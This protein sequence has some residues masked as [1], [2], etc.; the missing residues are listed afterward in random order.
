[1][2][3]KDKNPQEEDHAPGCA[4]GRLRSPVDRRGPM[5]LCPV[6]PRVPRGLYGSPAHG[7]H[8]QLPAPAAA[9]HPQQRQSRAGRPQSLSLRPPHGPAQRNPAHATSI[10][11]AAHAPSV[12]PAVSTSTA[13][14][15][16]AGRQQVRRQVH[17][18]QGDHHRQQLSDANLNVTLTKTQKNGVTYYIEDIY[19]RNIENLRT[20]FAENTYGRSY[21]RLGGGYGE[22]KRTPSPRSTATTTAWAPER[23]RHQERHP[24]QQQ[25][26]R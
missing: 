9:N 17:Q 21:H 11:R 24:V 7:Q 22:R 15:A 4:A 13:V 8:T 18:R 19:I 25:A 6:S 14:S 16:G 23:C 26:R 20:A 1:M 10:W 5:C 3:A 12:T 2:S